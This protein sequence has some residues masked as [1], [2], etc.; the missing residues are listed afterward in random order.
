MLTR[1]FAGQASL[2][3]AQ[4]GFATFRPKRWLGGCQSLRPRLRLGKGPLE[5]SPQFL[6]GAKHG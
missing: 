3:S 4:K 6:D 2:Q 5:Q 1:S